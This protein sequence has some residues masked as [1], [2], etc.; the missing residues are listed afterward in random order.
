MTRRFWKV[1][2]LVACGGIVLQ[3]GGCAGAAAVLIAQQL[4]SG[5]LSSALSALLAGL[6]GDGTG[7]EG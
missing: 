5:L 4:F 6:V 3:L 2:G 1:A 7:T